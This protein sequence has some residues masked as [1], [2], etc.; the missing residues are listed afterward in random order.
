M[1]PFYTL[2][3]FIL[4]QVLV[5]LFNIVPIFIFVIF[6]FDFEWFVEPVLAEVDS[7]LHVVE[8]VFYANFVDGGEL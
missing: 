7:F 8:F 4:V 2:N 5:L 1:I 6:P 3:S